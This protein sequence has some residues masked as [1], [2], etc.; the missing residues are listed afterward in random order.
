MQ[1]SSSTIDAI[2]EK[3]PHQSLTRIIGEPDYTSLHNMHREV[4]ANASAIHSTLGGGAHGHLGMVITPATYAHLSA[5][6]WI[7]PVHPVSIVNIPAGT[8]QHQANHLRDI[9]QQELGRFQLAD[10]VN[11]I[12][13]SQIRNAI[14]ED[15]LADEVNI[16][17][18]KFND[19]LVTTIQNLFAEYGS[20]K[21]T[22]VQEKLQELQ[23][24][25]YD[26]AVPLAATFARIE[27]LVDLAE[28]AKIPY[29]IEQTLAIAINIIE[30]TGKFGSALKDWYAL[31][32]VEQTWP[33]FKQHFKDARNMLKRTGQLDSASNPFQANAMR[34][35]IFEGVR[36]ALGTP[37]QVVGDQPFCGFTNEQGNP[38]F[39]G[40]LPT[41]QEPQVSQIE[42]VPS[43]EST[44]VSDDA[45][46]ATE[47]HSAF[48]AMSTSALDSKFKAFEERMLRLMQQQFVNS[49]GYNNGGSNNGSIQK[50][51]VG[52]S[53]YC[54]T[55]GLCNHISK[56]CK[57]K[58]EGHKD[59]A[60]F[61]NRMNGSNKGIK[62]DS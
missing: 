31:V 37:P 51:R 39:F 27:A 53:K 38:N 58:K 10:T 18:G 47:F 16:Q 4:K 50:N 17:T 28:A 60:T 29:T 46:K 30:K 44:D 61:T 19:P 32:P 6:P 11:T 5:T 57:N 3:M 23:S 56:D 54:W 14:E 7:D 49:G 40:Y 26:P 41:Q 8:A 20:V 45:S 33:K 13:T 21:A 52:H 12:L 2:K 15:Y 35:I 42:Q 24:K 9:H 43:G 59:E 36:D 55:H 34:Q 48:A 22:F 62:S 1:F 25:H